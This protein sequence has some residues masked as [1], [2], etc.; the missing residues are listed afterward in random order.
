MMEAGG[1]K[2][3]NEP[4]SPATVAAELVDDPDRPTLVTEAAYPFRIVSVNPAGVPL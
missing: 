3:P 1:W 2:S 4:C